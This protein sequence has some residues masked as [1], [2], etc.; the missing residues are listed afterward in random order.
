M[1]RLAA[2]DL[3]GTLLRSDGTV[4]RRT[5]AALRSAEAAGIAVALVTGRPPRWMAPVARATGH[6]GVAICANGAL[7]YDLHTE[8]VVGSDLIDIPVAQA[9][10]AAL[11]ASVPGLS[12]AAEFAPGFGH[13]ASY[14]HGWDLGE[15]EVRV[16]EA[17]ELLDQPVVK[18]LARHPTMDRDEL[19]TVAR[20]LLGADVTVTSSSTTEALLEISAPGVTKATALAG[21]AAR[22]GIAAAEV[23][24]F[25][26]M[27]N[28]LPMLAWAGRAVA[29][30]N[31]HPDV[32][33]LADEVTASNDDDGVALVLERLAGG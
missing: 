5:C 14:R 10:V 11:R 26:D 4:S 17:E 20:D 28:D 15:V 2:T 33:A 30:A 7:L 19:L 27:P 1:I 25:G 12:F 29:V 32:L 3:D 23:V 18:L 31:A 8:Q 13:E 24:A 6:T 9:T 21:L 22:Q 16:A